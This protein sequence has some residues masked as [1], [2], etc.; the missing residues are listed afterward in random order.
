MA[1]KEF[2]NS[3]EAT[4][5]METLNEMLNDPR[6]EDWANE[7]DDNYGQITSQ[8]LACT[9]S[10]YAGFMTQMFDDTL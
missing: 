9:R 2:H 1:G 6:L 7:T 8:S 4:E 10:A 3:V 5:F